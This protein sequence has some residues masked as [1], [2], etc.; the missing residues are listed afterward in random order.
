M[1]IAKYF[2]KRNIINSAIYSALFSFTFFFFGVIE[3]YYSNYKEFWFSL[4]DLLL[5]AGVTFVCVWALLTFIFMFL[6]KKIKGYAVAIIFGLGVGVYIQGNFMVVNYGTLDGNEIAW[7]DYDK[8]ALINSTIWMVIMAIPVLLFKYKKKLFIQI[9]KWLSLCLILVQVTTLTVLFFTVDTESDKISHYLSEED[10]FTVS[11]DKN[12]ITFVLDTFDGGLMT[13]ILKTHSEE[14]EERFKDFTL[15][16][17]AVGCATRTTRAMPY[18]LTGEFFVKQAP[19]REYIANAYAHTDFYRQLKESNFD[20]RIF[21]DPVYVSEAEM[22]VI[23]N[24]VD[25]KMEISAH[26]EM[27]KLL[28]QFTAFRYAPHLLKRYFWF[29]GNDFNL[30]QSAQGDAPYTIH[31][32][33][34]YGKLLDQGLTVT[35]EKNVFRLFHMEGAHGLYLMDEYGKRVPYG[36]STEERQARGALMI[37]S[38]Y[39]EMFKATGH[40]DSATIFIIADHGFRNTEHNVLLMAKLPGDSKPFT[41]SEAAVHYENLMPSWEEAFMPREDIQG[42]PIREVTATEH[43][44]SLFYIDVTPFFINGKAYDAD[45]ATPAGTLLPQAQ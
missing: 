8:W 23:D 41:I 9:V 13:D 35:E 19:Y 5:I 7:M 3:I 16:K 24:I 18:I 11:S 26:T 28:Y 29:Y 4:N 6:P 37:V 17:N 2:T 21:T 44:N 15:Y 10:M 40:Y 31:D 39:L 34:F 1:K 25:R 22:D 12:V 38:T 14:I 27:A 33:K 30:L 20:T 43:V 32:T 36:D 42:T 45:S